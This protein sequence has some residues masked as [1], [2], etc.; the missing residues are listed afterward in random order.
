MH[1]FLAT[2]HLLAQR[3]D[4]MTAGMLMLILGIGCGAFLIIYGILA[5]VCWFLAGCLKAIPEEHRK[6]QP[7]MVWLLLIPLFNIVWMFFVY[8]KIAESFKSYFDSIGRTDVGD[9]GRGL[10]LT[11]C[12]LVCCGIIP[13]VGACTGLAALVIWI[14]VLVKFSTLKGQIQNPPTGFTSAPPAV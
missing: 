12:I 6:Q 13:Y 5:V 14:I 11:Y 1:M 10:A 8:P 4:Q 3:N 9:C 7:N 2:A